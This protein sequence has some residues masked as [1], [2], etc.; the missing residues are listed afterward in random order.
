MKETIEERVRRAYQSGYHDGLKRS[1]EGEKFP[2]GVDW[3]II[4]VECDCVQEQLPTA[5]NAGEDVNLYEKLD[6]LK[7]DNKDKCSGCGKHKKIFYIDG[8]M[9]SK[10]EDWKPKEN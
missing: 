4:A 6:K 10:R 9:A 5:D 8:N 1:K 2:D 3:H 7:H